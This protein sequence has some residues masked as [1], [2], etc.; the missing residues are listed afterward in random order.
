MQRNKTFNKETNFKYEVFCS[1][2]GLEMCLK[3]CIENEN[4]NNLNIAFPL[5]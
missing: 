5:T 1:G 2:K 4:N 3:N